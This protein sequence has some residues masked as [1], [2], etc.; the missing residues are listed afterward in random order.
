MTEFKLTDLEGIGPAKA[1]NLEK[2]GIKTPLDF[3]LRGAKEVSR[4]TDISIDTALKLVHQV[5]E[6]LESEGKIKK[7]DSIKSLREVRHE[8]IKYKVNVPELDEM[9]AGGFETQ[10]TYEVYGPEGAG[11]TQLMLSL[12]AEANKLNHGVWVIDCEGT[13]KLDRLEQICEARGVKLDESLIQY[14]LLTDS[15]DVLYEL[16]ENAIQKV[17]DNNVKIIFIDGLVGLMRNMYHGR[18]ELADRQDTIEKILLKLKNISIFMNVCVILT[19]QVMSNPDPFGAKEKPIGGHVLGHNVKYI[20]AISKGLKNNR[21]MKLVKSP[22]EAQGEYQFF[23]NEEGVS[24][25][26]NLKKKKDEPVK[27]KVF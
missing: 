21:V 8:Q 17:Q 20:Y 23:L 4:I 10:S 18:G 13:L 24:Q 9:T 7:I 6:L 12:I 15:E 22:S 27:L 14:N 16:N 25:Y 26:E 11:K 5:K 3:V 1:K 2:D 19:N